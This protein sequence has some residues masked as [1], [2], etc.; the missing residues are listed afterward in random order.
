MCKKVLNISCNFLNTGRENQSGVWMQI[1]VSALVV[2]PGDLVTWWPGDHGAD[3]KL[4]LTANHP[5]SG[6]YH[7]T[8]NMTGKNQNSKP[9]IQFLLNAYHFPTTVKSRNPKPNHQKW[10]TLCNDNIK[11]NKHTYPI[12]FMWGLNKWIN[13]E[14]WE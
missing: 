13:R 14:S 9:E 2:Y 6:D 1:L 12:K 7:I 3:W 8:Y 10:G 11:R 5:A 4:R